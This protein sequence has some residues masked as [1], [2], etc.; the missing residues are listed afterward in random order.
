MVSVQVIS[1]LLWLCNHQEALEKLI[2]FLVKQTKKI[3]ISNHFLCIFLYTI[4]FWKG[5]FRS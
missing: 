4:Y 5:L 1:A 3:L 2:G